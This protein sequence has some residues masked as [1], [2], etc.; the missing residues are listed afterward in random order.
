VGRRC[1]GDDARAGGLPLCG[2]DGRARA[3]RPHPVLP[4]GLRSS[5]GHG[6]RAARA[7]PWRQDGPPP[8]PLSLP[9]ECERR[10]RTAR[11][12]GR[13]I[14]LSPPS[15]LQQRLPF[16]SIQ[17]PQM[18]FPAPNATLAFCIA[19]AAASI[20]ERK[21]LLRLPLASPVRTVS[22]RPWPTA[23]SVVY[24]GVIQLY[25]CTTLM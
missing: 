13:P 20:E 25:Y 12:R 22:D 15:G 3:R 1:G 14:L 5:G 16:A 4:G 21:R 18:G 6:V 23:I 8:P 19:F 24:A 11:G 7:P 10:R 2:G 9:H 17:T